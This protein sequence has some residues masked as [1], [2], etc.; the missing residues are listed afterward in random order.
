MNTEMPAVLREVLIFLLN[1][2]Q[3]LV[4]QFV[5]DTDVSHCMQVQTRIILACPICA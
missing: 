4:I 5:M 1:L 2:I 3:D